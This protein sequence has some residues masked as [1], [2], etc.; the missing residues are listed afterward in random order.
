MSVISLMVLGYSCTAD[1]RNIKSEIVI[2]YYIKCAVS[3]VV[4]V[5]KSL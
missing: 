5:T 4:D 2:A 1:K 3:V